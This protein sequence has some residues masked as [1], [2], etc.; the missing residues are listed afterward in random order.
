MLP[1]VLRRLSGEIDT[2]P[3]AIGVA[4]GMVCIA[5]AGTA[6]GGAI[7][8]AA[9]NHLKPH[10]LAGALALSAGVMVFISL[11]EMLNETT[12]NFEE[13]GFSGPVAAT[14]TY[15]TMFGGLGVGRVIDVIVHRLMSLQVT[16]DQRADEHSVTRQVV[17]ADK[18]C[19]LCGRDPPASSFSDQPEPASGVHV[20]LGSLAKDISASG[21]TASGGQDLQVV[22]LSAPVVTGP[23]RREQ[24]RDEECA[25]KCA[26]R[27]AAA[28][29][30]KGLDLHDLRCHGMDERS[31]GKLGVVSFLALSLHNLPEGVLVFTAAL[32]DPRLG[33]LMTIAI[34]LHN[35]PEGIAVAVPFLA[36][37]KGM[38]YAFAWAALS[39][40]SEIVGGAIGA[41]AVFAALKAGG[42][43]DPAGFGVTFG[44]TAGIMTFIGIHEL[45]P[46]ACKYDPSSNWMSTW[47]FIGSA[48][49]ALSIILLGIEA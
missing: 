27:K 11:T 25:A 6:L 47:F 3:Q 7:A 10:I 28:L 13:A 31:L 24:C 32:T 21:V 8:I 35:L 14:L 26:A 44:L 43:L 45:V 20:Q 19:P 37:G 30:V 38:W 40:I 18:Q 5:A 9:R 34:C 17:E 48:I 15:L 49:M 33:W 4:M 22:D 41:A 46:A 42:V 1:Q 36:A 12:T 23:R 2:S 29:G 16:G 39:G